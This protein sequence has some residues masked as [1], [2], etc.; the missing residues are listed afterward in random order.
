MD[1]KFI[2][3]CFSDN[4]VKF[5]DQIKQIKLIHSFIFVTT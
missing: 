1:T 2:R 4:F 3:I 5:K